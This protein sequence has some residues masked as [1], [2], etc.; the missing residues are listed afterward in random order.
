MKD[1]KEWKTKSKEQVQ[2][3]ENNNKSMVDIIQ[4]ILIITVNVND[5]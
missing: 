4:T 3:I 1:R 5:L 2:Q